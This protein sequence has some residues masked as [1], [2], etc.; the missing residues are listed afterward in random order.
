MRRLDL[1]EHESPSPEALASD[2]PFCFD[3]L[4]FSQWL[5]WV[6]LPRVKRILERGG[7]LPAE[8][9]IWP[10]AEECLRGLEP[11]ATYLLSLIRRFDDL[12][13]ENRRL[14]HRP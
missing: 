9:G 7:P 6:F 13:A 3:T 2:Q 14:A 8:S 4:S 5:Q 11:D 12:I 10:L 1:W